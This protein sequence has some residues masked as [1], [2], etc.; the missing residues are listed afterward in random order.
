MVGLSVVAQGLTAGLCLALLLAMV[1]TLSLLGV[2]AMDLRNHG[3]SPHAPTMS[4]AEMAADVAETLGAL[5]A[6]P[7]A[8]PARY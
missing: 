3:A 5:G 1:G 7:A 8:V 4:Y 6:A 2:I